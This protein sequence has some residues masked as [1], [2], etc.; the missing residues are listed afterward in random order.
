LAKRKLFINHIEHRYQ[1]HTKIMNVPFHFRRDP[2]F[3]LKVLL[4]F[5][6]YS[7]GAEKGLVQESMPEL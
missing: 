7:E 5:G 2:L 4:E 3:W 1:I 6:L